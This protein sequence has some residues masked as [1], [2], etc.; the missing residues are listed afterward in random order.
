MTMDENQVVNAVCAALK[1][2]GWKIV[3]QCDTSQ[4]GVDILAR[5]DPVTLHVE[6]KGNTSSK[7]ASNRFGMPMTGT[8]LFIQVAA[9]LLKTAELRCLNPGDEVAI[10]LPTDERLRARIARIAPVLEASRI[11][12]L[13]VAESLAL[14][15]WNA[16][17]VG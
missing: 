8:Q 14:D 3:S 16:T 6:A 10:A 7:Q 1:A 2:R 9:A 12:V 15:A 13:W 11:G 4:A 5:R 17:W